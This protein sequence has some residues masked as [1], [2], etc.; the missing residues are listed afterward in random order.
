MA[1]YSTAEE[2]EDDEKMLQ[3]NVGSYNIKDPYQSLPIKL[4]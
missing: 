1:A 4:Y 3:S 2:K